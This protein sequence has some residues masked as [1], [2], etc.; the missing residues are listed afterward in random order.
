[1]W[2]GHRKGLSTT[3]ISVKLTAAELEGLDGERKKHEQR[4]LWHRPNDFAES[5]GDAMRRLISEAAERRVEEK[6]RVDP[7]QVTLSEAIAAAPVLP[8][9]AAASKTGQRPRLGKTR[10]STRRPA[11]SQARI[12]G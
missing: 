9:A 5:R 2:R 4:N 1:M 11:R 12:R 7:R 10:P 6:R 8:R 3:T